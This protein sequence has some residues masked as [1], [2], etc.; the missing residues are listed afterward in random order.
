MN[1]NVTESITRVITLSPQ[2]RL[3]AFTAPDMR[4]QIESQLEAGNS[5]LVIDLSQTQ[6]L[7]SAGMAV[8]V[9]AL[10]SCRQK[11]GNVRLVWPQIDAVKRIISLTKFDRV[12]DIKATAQEAIAAF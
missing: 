9:S 6:F 7:D 12:F 11:N 10:K 4:Q 2:G 3:D 1:I 8:L 5:Q